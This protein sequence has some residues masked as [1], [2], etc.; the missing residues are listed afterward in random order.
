LRE[1]RRLREYENSVLRRIFGPKRYGVTREW[2]KQ[3]NGE[4]NDMSSSANIVRV[5][6]SRRRRRAGHVACMGK[7]ET[8]KG[9]W[10]ENL[11]RKTTWEAQV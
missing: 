2:R 10:W 7:G 9:F 11:K 4:L 6:I 5:I 8:Y 3:Y 1:E